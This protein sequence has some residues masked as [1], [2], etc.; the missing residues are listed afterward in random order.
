M[1]EGI[2]KATGKEERT[3]VWETY[4]G[5]KSRQGI[6]LGCSCDST[7]GVFQHLFTDGK[8]IFA[9]AHGMR[10]RI[11]RSMPKHLLAS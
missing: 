9:T 1:E 10:K 6:Y 2:T 3:T 5:V 4:F 8:T 7:T 11:N